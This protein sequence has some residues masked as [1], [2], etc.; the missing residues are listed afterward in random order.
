L[1]KKTKHRSVCRPLFYSEHTAYLFIIY[2]I[3]AF[4]VLVLYV[5]LDIR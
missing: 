2:T 1:L 4:S 5:S 3:S